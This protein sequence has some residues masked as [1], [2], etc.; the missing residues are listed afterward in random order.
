MLA[1]RQ[2]AGSQVQWQ[3]WQGKVSLANICPTDETSSNFFFSLQ[4]PFSANWPQM[5]PAQAAKP[6]EIWEVQPGP[7]SL[8]AEASKSFFFQ[9]WSSTNWF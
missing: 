8:S 6:P 3:V 2:G 4:F 1:K 9:S 7:Q 5:Q